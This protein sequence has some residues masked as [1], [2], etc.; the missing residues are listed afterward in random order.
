[1]RLNN[2]AIVVNRNSVGAVNADVAVKIKMFL[3]CRIKIIAADF[4]FLPRD[5]MLVRYMP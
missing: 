1:M 5:A 4:S 3:F 2:A